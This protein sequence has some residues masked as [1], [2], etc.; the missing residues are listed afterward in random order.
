[1]VLESFH[2]VI[3]M[4]YFEHKQNRRIDDLLFTLLKI[5]R[6]VMF[7]S[8][9]KEELGK[10]THRKKE[11]NRRH[12]SAHRIVN[13]PNNNELVL[14]CEED[15][16]W[17]VR[18]E[19]SDSY[20]DVIKVKKCDGCPLRCDECNI[21]IHMFTCTC[22]DAA[23]HQTICKHIHVLQLVGTASQHVAATESE[24]DNT[25][26]PGIISEESELA[27]TKDSAVASTPIVETVN[28]STSVCSYFKES[29]KEKCSKDQVLKKID[30]LK[31]LVSIHDDDSELAE[32]NSHLT[33]C[34]KILEANTKVSQAFLIRKRPAPNANNVPQQRFQT[35][36]KRRKQTSLSLGKPTLPLEKSVREQLYEMEST[37]CG[38]CHRVDDQ[39]SAESVQWV[40]CAKCK[41]WVHQECTCTTNTVTNTI[42][43]KD[44]S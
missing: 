21:C 30:R 44:C 13:A 34:I 40:E 7:N 17:K 16:K 14:N 2:R 41:L 12:S 28:K 37:V 15:G 4:V 11:I 9:R 36:T 39:S 10:V 35:A 32:V 3:K 23:L 8:L 27:S 6:D 20:Y 42:L 26:L 1:M 43:C 5:N 38:V 31:C 22:L 29:A 24:V 33:S 19:R 25:L 18:S